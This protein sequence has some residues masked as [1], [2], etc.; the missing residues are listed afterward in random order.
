MIKRGRVEQN[1]AARWRT[2]TNLIVQELD[3][4]DCLVEHR[5]RVRLHARTPRLIH[6]FFVV[7]VVVKGSIRVACL[8]DLNKILNFKNYIYGALTFPKGETSCWSAV[9]LSPS[10]SFLT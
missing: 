1:I 7:V 6:Q 2:Y 8:I 4:L 9:T 10:F 3:V 5:C